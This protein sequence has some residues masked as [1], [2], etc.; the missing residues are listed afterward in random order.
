MD[1]PVLARLLAEWCIP[2]TPE[3]RDQ[4]RG[5]FAYRA[6]TLTEAA[7]RLRAA[8]WAAIQEDFKPS[9]PSTS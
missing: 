4:I 5:T 9:P 2:D 3:N 1:D 6:L 7:R 8:A